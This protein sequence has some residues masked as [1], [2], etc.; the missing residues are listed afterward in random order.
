M[1]SF[2]IFHTNCRRGY[3]YFLTDDVLIKKACSVELCLSLANVQTGRG[4]QGYN[5][6][7]PFNFGPTPCFSLV[8]LPCLQTSMSLFPFASHLPLRFK[9]SMSNVERLFPLFVEI[10]P[11]YQDN[12]MSP[13]HMNEQM[14]LKH[15][16]R[17]GRD[18]TYSS[19]NKRCAWRNQLFTHYFL[20]QF[21]KSHAI[22]LELIIIT[23]FN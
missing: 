2:L 8:I 10:P 14:L 6:S 3:L 21:I 19:Y 17:R 1:F 12:K 4:T 15:T 9:S 22:N 5:I 16:D 18:R 20:S 13:F 23:N 7:P 11:P